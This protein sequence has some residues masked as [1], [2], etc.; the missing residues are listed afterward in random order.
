MLYILILLLLFFLLVIHF[1]MG[2]HAVCSE[3][4]NCRKRYKG[5]PSRF[6]YFLRSRNAHMY[7]ITSLNISM[8]I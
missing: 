5:G 8:S 3:V 4:L 7:E 1:V 6:K 2:Q